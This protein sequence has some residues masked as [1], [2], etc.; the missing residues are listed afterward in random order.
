MTGPWLVIHF[1]GNCFTWFLVKREMIMKILAL[2][3][4]YESLIY[5]GFISIN[6]TFKQ[7]TRLDH[8]FTYRHRWISIP[9]Q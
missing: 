9:L 6:A 4:F 5:F 7:L 3:E 1:L 2:Q 8:Y